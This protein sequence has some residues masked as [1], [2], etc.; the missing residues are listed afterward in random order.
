MIE[1]KAKFYSVQ[2]KLPEK[3]GRYLCITSGGNFR[4]LSYSE[5]YHLFNASDSADIDTAY[6]WSIDC[7]YW[8]DTDDFA[9]LRQVKECGLR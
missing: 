8:A 2:E 4:I 7:N 1:I 3:S 9:E 5:K 6:T